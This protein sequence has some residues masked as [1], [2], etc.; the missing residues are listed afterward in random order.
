MDQQTQAW[1]PPSNADFANMTA[2]EKRVIIAKDVIAALNAKRYAAKRK[3]Y[4][5]F[6]D[7]LS[8]EA[9]DQLDK[10][11][12]DKKCDVCAIGAVFISA[13]D[14]F[15]NLKCEDV[16]I[17]TRSASTM[18]FHF[19]QFGDRLGIN[20][21]TSSGIMNY[22][23]DFFDRNQLRLMEAAFECENIACYLDTQ[24][25][26]RAI[27]FGRA[28]SNIENRLIKIMQNVIENDGTFNP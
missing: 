11:I 27:E 25:I 22:M 1:T 18:E 7:P 13:V 16:V 6:M 24:I 3:V 19:E 23:T 5:E 14:R 2:P 17:H 12:K 4:V 8:F 21:I 28:E 15:D 20:G 26:N 9:S 10:V